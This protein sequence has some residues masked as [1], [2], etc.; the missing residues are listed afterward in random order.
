MYNF[1]LVYTKLPIQSN[2]P[3][4]R[5]FSVQEN[6]EGGRDENIFK[7]SHDRTV[8]PNFN[9]DDVIIEDEND[10]FNS[11]DDLMILETTQQIEE[12]L[13]KRRKAKFDEFNS[14][15]ESD[16]LKAAETAEKQNLRELKAIA[17]SLSRTLNDAKKSNSPPTAIN[18]PLPVIPGHVP[19]LVYGGMPPVNYCMNWPHGNTWFPGN[20]GYH[21][22]GSAP[23]FMPGNMMMPLVYPNQVQGNQSFGFN[24]N[25]NQNYQM[26]PHQNTIAVSVHSA[27][28][29]NV[30][31][32][33]TVTDEHALLQ[34]IQVVVAENDSDIILQDLG[35]I[36]VPVICHSETKP[37]E[38]SNLRV[39]EP[40]NPDMMNNPTIKVGEPQIPEMMKNPEFRVDEPQIQDMFK[41]PNIRVGKPQYPDIKN[42][43][44]KI[45]KPRKLEMK[46]IPELKF[47]K[48]QKPK[49]KNIPELIT[50][51][52]EDNLVMTQSL[53]GG[54]SG[55]KIPPISKQVHLI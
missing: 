14:E 44:L 49:K 37:F 28:N 46:K 11:E 9:L 19:N 42:H 51:D 33:N 39:V 18:Q 45:S 35:T 32:S 1:L 26:G 40:L 8:I 5:Y 20:P 34:N 47:A 36:E 53:M 54:K 29:N 25:L 24:T 55:K 31:G 7:H 22:Y 6:T 27:Q 41:N 50:L 3:A 23:V 48:V 12:E 43:E 10:D 38:I 2:N 21:P 4:V 30:L 15:D 52:N 17:E 13:S 16:L